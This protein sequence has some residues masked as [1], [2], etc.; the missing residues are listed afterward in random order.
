MA[1]SSDESARLSARERAVAADEA[2]A[3]RLLAQ[4]RAAHRAAERERN[5]ARKL[6]SR[7]ARKLQHTLDTARAQLAADRAVLDAQVAKL[8]EARSE[9]HSA[10]AA[11][12]DRRAGAWR[13]LEARGKRLDAEWEETNRFHAEQGAA[14]EARAAALAVSEKVDADAKTRLQGEVAALREEA[15]ALDARA[16]NA[17]QLVDELEQRRAQLRAESLV[18]A[19]VARADP[20]A[21][22]GVSLDRTTDRDLG[23]WVAELDEREERVRLERAAV[24]ALFAAVSKDQAEL[25][26]RRRVLAEQFTQLAAARAQWQEAE[27]ATV[28]EMEH[29]AGTLRR[30][31]TELDA[32]DQRLTRADVRRREDAYTLWQLRLRLEAWQS[33]LVVYEMRWHT[34]REEMDAEFNLRAAALARRELELA[35]APVGVDPDS[36][37][38]ALVVPEPDAP[39]LPAELASLREELERMAAV[40]L[41]AEL[42]EPPDAPESELPWG[43]EEEEVLEALPV[44]P[45]DADVLLFG[46]P[47]RAA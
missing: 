12:R 1:H 35:P 44:E 18:P 45:D 22:P 25:A 23:K 4:A 13:D 17:R 38:M 28:A 26:D 30:R 5:R 6:A 3:Q 9:L 11:D 46:A 39:A 16:R 8:N 31:E 14:L 7:M 42:P 32:R 34:E 15:A 27:S 19:V 29:L 43:A 2:E 24:H 10:S 33:K 47:A 36:I 20:P 21:E 37:P 40:L 41:D